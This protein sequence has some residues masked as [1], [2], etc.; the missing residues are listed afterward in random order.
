MAQLLITYDIADDG[1][2]DV[3]REA[4]EHIGCQFVQYS[5]YSVEGDESLAER[6]RDA[7]AELKKTGFFGKYD[8]VRIFQFVQHWFP[9]ERGRIRFFSD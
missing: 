1:K 4:L 3:F 7:I 9:V 5:V 8:D 2:R 6:L